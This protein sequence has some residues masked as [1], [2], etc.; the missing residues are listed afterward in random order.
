MAEKVKTMNLLL[1]VVLFALSLDPTTP[2]QSPFST[3]ISPNA[4][5]SSASE[6]AVELGQANATTATFDALQYYLAANQQYYRLSSGEN[7]RFNKKMTCP[8]TKQ[9]VCVFSLQ[10]LTCAVDAVR[11]IV[12]DDVLPLV[13]KVMSAASGGSL[14]FV[15]DFA[16][17]EITDV[18]TKFQSCLGALDGSQPDCKSMNTVKNC[19]SAASSLLALPPARAA[20]ARLSSKV[21]A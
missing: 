17:K 5:A 2:Q 8:A 11:T 4:T 3:T 10:P 1:F 7:C 6:D 13:E 15:I 18:F 20:L 21:P 9:K 19:A 16:E 12:L 14:D